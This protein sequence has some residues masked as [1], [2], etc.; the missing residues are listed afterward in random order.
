LIQRVGNVAVLYRRN[1]DRTD[2]LKEQAF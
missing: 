1:P 2:I